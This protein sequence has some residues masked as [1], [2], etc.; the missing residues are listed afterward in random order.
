MAT[1][2][3]PEYDLADCFHE[4]VIL[5][6]AAYRQLD[7]ALGNDAH[8]EEA[9]EACVFAERVETSAWA[10]AKALRAAS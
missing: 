3:D 7:Q 8:K 6:R 5:L 9:V 10:L 1:R 2:L 4:E